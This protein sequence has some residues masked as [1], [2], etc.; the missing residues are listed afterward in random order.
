MLC[1][2][3]L[4]ITGTKLKCFLVNSK[5]ILISSYIA[6]PILCTQSVQLCRLAAKVE[7]SQIS[8]PTCYEKVKIIQLDFR[9]ALWAQSAL[10][11]LAVPLVNT[12][13]KTVAFLAERRRPF[14]KSFASANKW[15]HLAIFPA[16]TASGQ[17][18]Q[19]G[20]KLHWIDL[21]RIQI[22]TV[23]YGFS[24]AVHTALVCTP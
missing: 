24:P 8:W 6:H 1:V 4:Y 3:S 9:E 20:S 13:P 15:S 16:S 2:H 7:T 17:T 19:S 12:I 5:N 22:R 21:S 11:S 23:L 18:E 10:L 14:L